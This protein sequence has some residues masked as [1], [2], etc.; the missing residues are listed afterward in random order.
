[1]RIGNKVK[2]HKGEYAGEIGFI[3][4]KTQHISLDGFCYLVK[5]KDGTLIKCLAEDLELVTESESTSNTITITREDFE[6][7]VKKV[8]APSVYVDDINDYGMITAVCLSGELV[9]KKLAR[10]LFGDNG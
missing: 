8:V 5:L 9:C 1:M 6:N 3:E 2:I 7:A 10:E 4:K